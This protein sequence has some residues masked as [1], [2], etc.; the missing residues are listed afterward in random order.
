MY[1]RKKTAE[2][3]LASA[4]GTCKIYIARSDN[5]PELRIVIKEGRSGAVSAFAQITVDGK[6]YTAQGNCSGITKLKNEMMATCLAIVNLNNAIGNSENLH[7]RQIPYWDM[8][9]NHKASDWPYLFMPG[10]RIEKL[11]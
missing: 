9:T 1:V 2:Q 7:I 10:C 5:Y 6:R 4:L 11:F 8:R 3:G